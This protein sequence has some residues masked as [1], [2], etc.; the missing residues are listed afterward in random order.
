MHP[1]IA[2]IIAEARAKIL[3]KMQFV[4]QQKKSLFFYSLQKQLHAM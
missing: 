1:H 4:K 2:R 3:D